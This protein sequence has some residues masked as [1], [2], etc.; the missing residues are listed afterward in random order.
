M[1]STQ[2]FLGSNWYL[3]DIEV[4]TS[5]GFQLFSRYD[6]STSIAVINNKGEAQFQSPLGILKRA[7][8]MQVVDLCRRNTAET[9]IGTFPLTGTLL[10]SIKISDW[11]RELLPYRLDRQRGAS[12]IA[13]ANGFKLNSGNEMI[14]DPIDAFNVAL[15]ADGSVSYRART[16]DYMTR[17]NFAKDRKIER[18]QWILSQIRENGRNVNF[19]VIENDNDTVSFKVSSD[20]AVHKRFREWIDFSSVS[21]LWLHL[22]LHEVSLWDGSIKDDVSFSYSNKDRGDIDVVQA[23][24]C[25][26][27]FSTRLTQSSNGIY[28]LNVTKNRSYLNSVID[29]KPAGEQIRDRYQLL[30]REPAVGFVI[31]SNDYIFAGV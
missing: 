31:R 24:C 16:A 6:G 15:Q 5:K 13:L 14:W 29:I 8:K 23:A 7:E 2:S 18:L 28:V 25:L 21:T 22:F 3:G 4:L 9:R 11:K 20:F 27:G 1:Q 12:T 26:R 19:S 30:L 17:F 10:L